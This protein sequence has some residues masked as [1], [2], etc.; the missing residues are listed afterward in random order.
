MKKKV[1]P[2]QHNHPFQQEITQLVIQGNDQ[3]ALTR[4]KKRLLFHPRDV[5]CLREAG[6]LSRRLRKLS[7]AKAFYRKALTMAPGEAG[8]L[9]G[10]GLT[11]YDEKNY[12]EA[13]RYYLAAL[14]SYPG[15]S[16]CHNNYAVMLGKMER[17]D[18]ALH[19]Y[20]QALSLNPDYTDACLGV[21]T[22]LTLKG[23]LSQA[24]SLLWQVQAQRPDDMHCQNVLGMVLLQQGKY[25]QGWACYRARYA[26]TNPHRFFTLPALNLPY[27][28]GEDLTGKTILIRTEQGYGD[29]IQFCRFVR[30]LKL[31]KNA[32]RV[33]MVGRKGLESVMKHLPGVDRYLLPADKLALAEVDCWSMLLDLP[34]HFSESADP[35]AATT[36]Y[37]RRRGRLSKKW[38]LPEKGL[39]IGVV[40]KGS[41]DHKRDQ[42]RSL[43]HLDELAPLREIPGIVWVSLQKGQGEAEVAGWPEMIPCGEQFEHYGDT[44]SVLSQLDL[45][46]GVDTSVI[47]L[48]GAMGIPCWVMLS[49][50][51]RDWR[52]RQGCTETEWYP[53]MRLFAQQSQHNWQGVVA[54]VCDALMA[55]SRSRNVSDK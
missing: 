34:A 49:S 51:A 15:Y 38:L 5:W 55:F 11:L 50:F 40:W 18:E 27:W 4:I 37:L 14:K 16:A 9:G 44:A 7:D 28:Q 45:V 39:R 41:A 33:V 13:E 53:G 22:T 6:K 23:E 20:Q 26:S 29:E 30:Q 3:E 32:E 2:R 46:I 54:Q 8:T 43:P 17:H 24:E 21:C 12:L 47:H 35:F 25:Q 10:M 52:W 19:H 42:Y 1:A 48:A 31:E 36:P